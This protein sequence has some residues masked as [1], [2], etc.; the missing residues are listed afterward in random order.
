MFNT[1]TNDGHEKTE[2]R[3]GGFS[4]LET[5][6]YE[7]TV[8][9]AYGSKS[10]GGATAVNL[11]IDMNGTEHRETIWVTNKQGETF[12]FNKTDP[13]KKVSLPGFTTINDLCLVAAGMPLSGVTT[14]EKVVKVYDFE[15]R[16]EVPKSV[17]VI[18]E[19]VGK[20]ALFAVLKVIE[21]VNEK[22]G[23][24]YVATAKTRELNQ[25]D[26]VF[27]LATKATVAEAMAAHETGKP[28]EV[29]FHDKWLERNKGKERDKR[30][31]KDGAA[32]KAG[33]PP[34]SGNTATAARPSLFGGKS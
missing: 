28:L 18:M 3:L 30:S 1:M 26:K 5:D 2:D 6:I 33:G 31:I 11:I 23:D 21:N 20:K 19:L 10:D 9:V 25:I 29:S 27:D 4:R 32:A 24:E 22:R 17:P 8:K 34:Q 13:T 16:A 12:F 15:A 7:G 14:E